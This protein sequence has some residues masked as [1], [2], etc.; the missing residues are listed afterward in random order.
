VTRSAGARVCGRRETVEEAHV[1]AC[2]RHGGRRRASGG[3]S[4]RSHAAIRNIT[5]ALV[6]KNTNNPFL[7]PGAGWLQEGREGNSTGR[8]NA[9]ISV[10]AST[11][12]GDEEAQIVADLI[13]QSRTGH[14][15]VAP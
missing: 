7:R 3:C 13:T 9:S 14:W 11:A 10:P 12:A 1:E 15:R 6:P 5:F 2:N 4:E 8:S